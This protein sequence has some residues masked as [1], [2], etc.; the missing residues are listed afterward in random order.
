[1]LN[2]IQ[3]YL[4]Y[5]AFKRYTSNICLKCGNTI[6]IV[7][8]L[9]GAIIFGYYTFILYEVP[10]KDVQIYAKRVIGSD[11]ADSLH[12][13]VKMDYG[14]NVTKKYKKG[15]KP[16]IEL[17]IDIP[18]SWRHNDSLKAYET[19]AFENPA[20]GVIINYD[21]ESIV[22]TL[23][24]KSSDFGNDVFMKDVMSIFQIDMVESY[25]PRTI[26]KSNPIDSFS[27]YRSVVSQAIGNYKYKEQEGKRCA[28]NYVTYNKTD[29]I[30]GLESFCSKCL[31]AVADTGLNRAVF[32]PS[33]KLLTRPSLFSDYDISQEYFKFTIDLPSSGEK[34]LLEIDFGGATEFSNIYP[35]PDLVSMSA[36][37]YND[38]EKIN[39]I[40]Y[41]GLWFHAKFKQ[42]EN[43][44]IL[45]MFIVT[46]CFGFFVALFFSSFFKWLK[47]WSR[48][49]RMTLALEKKKEQ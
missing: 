43:V 1:M 12:L 2:F 4:S 44:Q 30:T 49:Y 9:L 5:K 29:E 19:H 22:R 25:P 15:F 47:L 42:M 17:W 28:I 20:T 7:T 40:K 26:F 35:T 14:L 46:T 6:T 34:T 33:T 39:I 27:I 18:D 11:T 48:R 3:T 10:I 38:P 21:P 37:G 36:I 13:S 45:R 16:G 23:A 8:S 31:Y 41:R 32:I 24:E